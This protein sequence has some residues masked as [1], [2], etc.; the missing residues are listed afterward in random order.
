MAITLP[1]FFYKFIFIPIIIPIFCLTFLGKPNFLVKIINKIIHFTD[2]FKGIEFINFLIL[3]CIILS[4]VAYYNYFDAQKTF[5]IFRKQKGS[6]NNPLYESIL[7]DAH[8]SERNF[9]IYLAGCI[10]LLIVHKLTERYLRI[11]GKEKQ[12]KEIQKELKTLCP[13]KDLK[14]K[15]N[16]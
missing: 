9:Y 11:A 12:I 13:E 14:T 10:L 7:R 5:E 1:M 6:M 3:V 8:S 16:D 4:G 2:P 15:K